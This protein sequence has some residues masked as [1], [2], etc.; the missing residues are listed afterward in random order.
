MKKFNYFTS[1]FVS[2]GHPDKV[3]DQISDAILDACLA[4]D[5]NARVAC[6][7]FCTTGQV[8]VGGEIT[9]TT[10]IDVQDIVRKKIEEIG[11]RDGMGFDANCGVLSAIHAQ[12]PDIAMGVDIGGKVQ[13]SEQATRS[14]GKGMTQSLPYKPG[15]EAH[16][17]TP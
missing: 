3:S 12:S 6:E 16:L 11:Y 2:P 9:T 1:E 4:E 5:P 7:V 15:T 8:I 14:Q 10:Y 13:G 17:L